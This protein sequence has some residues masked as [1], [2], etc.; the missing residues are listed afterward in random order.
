M[1]ISSLSYHFYFLFLCR[2]YNINSILVACVHYKYTL[3]MPTEMF[4]L[5]KRV[6]DQKCLEIACLV[7]MMIFKL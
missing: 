2:L 3:E 5:L 1:F 6:Y 7:D 4:F